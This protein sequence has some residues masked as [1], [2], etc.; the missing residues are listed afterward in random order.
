M[1]CHEIYLILNFIHSILTKWWIEWMM[2]KRPPLWFDFPFWQSQKRITTEF[3][4]NII[5][6]SGE[7]RL[8]CNFH[9]QKPFP[10]MSLYTF[11]L[12]LFRPS[13]VTREAADEI[14]GKKIQV[15]K[16]DVKVIH[17]EYSKVMLPMTTTMI[18]CKCESVK[19]I[20]VSV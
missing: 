10:P 13:L 16:I 20:A 5:F 3:K 4:T 7:S 1:C 2:G 17:T 19:F 15:Y 6:F 9:I 12:K 8:A 18:W 11:T 14:L